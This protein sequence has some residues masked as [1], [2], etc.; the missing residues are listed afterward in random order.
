MATPF[1]PQPLQLLKERYPKAVAVAYN[2]D[3]CIAEQIIPPSKRPEHIFDTEEGI[4]IIISRDNKNGSEYIHF[5]G[6]F[7]DSYQGPMNMNCMQRMV[8][9]FGA[10]SGMRE[11]C[12]LI[13]FS[14][15]RVP[16]WLVEFATLN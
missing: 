13:G 7:D 15:D 4:R 9:L 10:I 16:H 12:R 14:K 5:S 6:S 11:P 8:D 3:K 1:N 2:V